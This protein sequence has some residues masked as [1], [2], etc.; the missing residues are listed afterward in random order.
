[1][2]YFYMHKRIKIVHLDLQTYT[3]QMYEFPILIKYLSERLNIVRSINTLLRYFNKI[4]FRTLYYRHLSR[5]YCSNIASA[6]S[7]NY[8]NLEHCNF[9]GKNARKSFWDRVYKW[10]NKREINEMLQH[11][12]RKSWRFDSLSQAM[13]HSHVKVEMSRTI[14]E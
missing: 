7:L 12:R 10:Q 3:C 9:A 6:I 13:H 2:Y 5:D 1:M 14:A 4:Y 11:A 8:D